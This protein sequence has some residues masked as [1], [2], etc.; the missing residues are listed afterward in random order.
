MRA[1]QTTVPAGCPAASS[2]RA[3]DPSKG[4][5]NCAGTL[6]QLEDLSRCTAGQYS[7]AVMPILSFDFR[8][9]T[10]RCS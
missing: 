1:N 5:H 2:Y 6:S 7:W 9:E 4:E 3:D 8:N 10:P